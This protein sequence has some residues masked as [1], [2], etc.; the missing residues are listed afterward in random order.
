[1]TTNYSQAFFDNPEVWDSAAWQNRAA[2]QERARLAVEWLPTE[3]KLILDV[4]CGNGVYTNLIEP[5]RFKVGLDLSRIALQQITA[6]HLQADASSLPFEDHSFDASLSMEMLEHLPQPNYQAALN[7]LRRVARRYILITV[8]YKEKL[9]YNMVICPVCKHAFHPYNHVRAYHRND[10]TTLF[11]NHTR[12]VKLEAVV[13]IKRTAFAA[14]WNLYRNHQHRNGRNFPRLA[15]CPQCGYTP[16]ENSASVQKVSRPRPG[17]E[18]ISRL[19]PKQSS[20]RWWMA[21]YGI[22]A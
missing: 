7:E 6:P 2:D 3:A 18:F 22:D 17:R 15:V 8:P 1:M 16:D 9:S 19:W 4:G 20:Y 21:L 13:P 14:L 10:F 12:L 11:G 5:Y